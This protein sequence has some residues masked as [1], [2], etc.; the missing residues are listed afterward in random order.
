MGVSS[1]CEEEGERRSEEEVGRSV[2]R[3]VG[4]RSSVVGRS[5]VGRREQPQK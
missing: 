4:R 1:V 5:A 2:G 3:S